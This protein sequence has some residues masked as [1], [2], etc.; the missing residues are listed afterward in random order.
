MFVPDAELHESVFN[1]L[2][3]SNRYML[4][5]AVQFTPDYNEGTHTQYMFSG[6]RSLDRYALASLT[7]VPDGTDMLTDG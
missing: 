7:N 6:R 3:V 4:K 1:D 2:F 5:P